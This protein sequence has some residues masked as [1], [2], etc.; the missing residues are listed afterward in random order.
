MKKFLTIFSIGVCLLCS[1]TA[2]A[3]SLTDMKLNE[4]L[5]YNTDDF[6]DDFGQHN[7]WIEIFNQGYGS[8]DLGGCF[9]SNDPNNLKKYTI[10]RGDVLTKIKP[11]QH[12]LFWADDQPYRGTF[13]LSFTVKPSDVIYLVSNNGTT[14]LDQVTL[15]ASLE[16]NQS[17][18]RIVDGEG[19]WQ[20]M[21]ITSPSTNNTTMDGVSKSDRMKETDPYGWIMAIMA[22][23]VV[24]SAL[25]VLFL[26]FKGIGKLSIKFLQKKADSAPQSTKHSVADTSGE[27]YAAIA[28]ALHLYAT[29][30]DIHDVEDT[31]LTINRT[32]RSYSPWSSKRQSMRQ[33]PIIRKR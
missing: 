13:H 23:S 2:Q 10:P 3:Q 22:M 30:S 19:E 24:F 33:E 14:I 5:V 15:P 12:T 8:A 4:I 32:R 21:P 20:I 26:C 31:I 16:P 28:M 11:R 17:Y 27:T 29:E 7:A 1:L 18:G 25:I 9:L 6:Q